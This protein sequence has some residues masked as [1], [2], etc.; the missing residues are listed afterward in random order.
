M[1]LSILF[2]GLL[3]AAV[4]TLLITNGILDALP[5]AGVGV[6]V[7]ALTYFVLLSASACTK[8][9]PQKAS[10]HTE[11][12]P[13]SNP[14]EA[15]EKAKKKKKK[16]PASQKKAAEVAQKGPQPKEEEEEDKEEEKKLSKTQLRRQR[17]RKKK[18]SAAEAAE[19]AETKAQEETRLKKAQEKVAKEAAKKAAQQVEAEN[20]AKKQFKAASAEDGWETQKTKERKTPAPKATKPLDTPR[21]K[22]QKAGPAPTIE[23]FKATVNVPKALLGAIIGP[24]GVY[25]QAITAKTGAR[26]T[27]PKEDNPGPVLIE[28]VDEK[29]VNAAK[30]AIESILKTGMSSITHPGSTSNKVQ[31]T[32][33]NQIG[34]IIG[35]KGANIQKLQRDLK[36]AIKMPER[37]ALKLMVTVSGGKEQVKQAKEAIEDLIHLGFSKIT[38]PDFT[39]LEVSYPAGSFGKLIGPRGQNIKSIQGNTTCRVNIPKPGH[40]RYKPDTIIIVGPPNK[41]ESAKKQVLNTLVEKEYVEDF[42]DPNDPNYEEPQDD[43]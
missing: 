27:T 14:S 10:Q 13:P 42:G 36:V 31:L 7:A 15:A 37:D 38:H 3:G 8:S 35:P 39:S 34:L 24:Q 4:C 28:G 5:G 16:K 29:G 9:R 19:V 40:P 32:D 2:S 20:R 22:D 17:I 11:Q 18:E 1:V 33:S 12:S 26:I 23:R 25:V 6:G 43:Y 30:N 41:L 21:E